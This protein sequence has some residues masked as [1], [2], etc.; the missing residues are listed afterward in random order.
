MQTTTD[1]AA[2]ARQQRD[3]VS[4]SRN[5]RL[6]ALTRAPPMPLTNLVTVGHLAAGERA[7]Q[8]EGERQL[9]ALAGSS[10]SRKNVDP[11]A[12]TNT[13]S[14]TWRR[15]TNSMQMRAVMKNLR[16]VSQRTS[17]CKCTEIPKFCLL[18]RKNNQN[19][20]PTPRHDS[21]NQFPYSPAH[22]SSSCLFNYLHERGSMVHQTL[23]P[24]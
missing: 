3:V 19:N 5:S 1:R 15:A 7:R 16:R 22:L 23:A 17:V 24:K 18:S 12:Q 21:W 9:G 10:L 13:G 11:R 4:G 8:G 6:A 20:W 14:A 2:G